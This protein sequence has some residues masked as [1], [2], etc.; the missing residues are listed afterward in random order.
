MKSVS[1]LGDTAGDP[2]A[3]QPVEVGEITLRLRPGKPKAAI[4]MNEDHPA[5]QFTEAQRE[6]TKAWLLGVDKRA[7]EMP[8]SKPS[9]RRPCSGPSG[10][11]FN[12]LRGNPEGRDALMSAAGSSRTNYKTLRGL[13]T[14]NA[15][16]GS[17][18]YPSLR[19]SAKELG[20]S[21]DIPS[22]EEIQEAVTIQRGLR[23]KKSHLIF[24]KLDP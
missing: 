4:G 1:I 24:A 9:T 7:K 16:Q 23:S 10:P 15:A 14:R 11:G 13:N 12:S 6:E 22:V 19:P 5:E 17:P 20:F 21:T 3:S 2:Q 8:R 18:S